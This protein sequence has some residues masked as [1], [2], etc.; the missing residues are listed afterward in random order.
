[1]QDN[2]AQLPQIGRQ[3]R[4]VKLVERTKRSIKS[5]RERLRRVRLTNELGEHRI[6]L[7]RR[8]KAEIAAGIDPNA[9][10]CRFLV[11]SDD[12]RTVRN[13]ARLHREAACTDRGLG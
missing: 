13:D 5:R 3:S 4:N 9:G 8:R 11:S 6:E 1:M 7:R 12:T 2:G 10:T